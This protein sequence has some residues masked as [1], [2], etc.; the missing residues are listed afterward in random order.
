MSAPSLS[1]LLGGKRKVPVIRQSE[2]AECGL[3]C[4]A[5]IANACGHDLDLAAMRRRFG[6][7]GV[8]NTLGSLLKMADAL[9][10]LA[11]PL[12]VEL[13]YLDQLKL[14]TLLHW[15][16]SH[17]VVLIGVGR[18]GIHIHDPGCGRRFV[19]MA[20][21]DQC[22]TGVAVEFSPADG[23]E[24]VRDRRRIS[25]GRLS[26]RVQ[27]L[28]T[29]AIQVLLL[30]LLL[31]LLTLT[32][33]LAMQW[34]LDGVLTAA[35]THLLTLVGLGCLFIVGFQA[36]TQ[37]LRGVL[38]GAIG[39]SLKAQWSGNL[40][41]RLVHLPYAYFERREVGE[42]M[43]RFNS[44]QSVQQTLSVS[45]VDAVLDGLTVVLVL[46][47][48]ALYSL[49]L[50]ALV[51]LAVSL[52]GLARWLVYRLNYRLN[53]ERL[54]YEARQQTLMLEAVRA[55][56]SIKLA[57]AEGAR[58]SRV[59][60]ALTEVA[61]R[62]ARVAGLSAVMA[63]LSRLIF[64]LLRVALL[65]LGAWMIMDGRFSVGAMVAFIAFADVFAQKAAALVDHISELRLLDLHAG[66]IADIALEVPEQLSSTAPGR[67]LSERP[68][69]QVRGVSFRYRVDGPRVLEDLS[70]EIGAGEHVAI[71][72]ASGCGKTTL[73][74]LLLGLLEPES[75]CICVDGVD[76]RH[77]GIG[78]F[79]A[80]FG[81]VM[82]SDQL[83][84]GTIADNI[85]FFDPDADLDR[86]VAAA[87][88]AAIHDDIVALPMAYETPVGDLG[89]AL[90]GGQKQRV[91]LARALYRQPLI[92]L[93]DEA[94]SHLDVH[95]ERRINEQISALPIT[96]IVIAHRPQTIAAADRVLELVD[97]RLVSDAAAT[98]LGPRRGVAG[99][100]SDSLISLGA[101][102]RPGPKP[103]GSEVGHLDNLRSNP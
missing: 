5:M 76:A 91:L 74:K 37:A 39:A 98:A 15:R 8:G 97:G 103:D 81:A 38:V 102:W 54:G 61:N 60:N 99:G 16:M 6:G 77:V 96:R 84:S 58:R 7:S 63:A 73:A 90:S 40:F 85:A 45:F 72:G 44:V 49:P 55:I 4:L 28:A 100:R 46:L 79:R 11:R 10:L 101:G 20:E 53:E 68:V 87:R 41:G 94:T 65:W 93:L 31:E 71:V 70:F 34:I 64:G 36:L 67:P 66:R 51:V 25:L 12:R 92:L 22:F 23:F 86:I 26:G 33:P 48:L 69:L 95:C 52:Y 57:G 29:G 13:G 21:V 59:A 82:Q 27:G 30:A 78:R 24:P 35:D 56:L 42:I 88:S 89:A 43:S 32:L 83:M 17:F 1:S 19:P 14:P 18:K 3:A 2:Y 50:T 62:D 80:L 75:G 47:V 9:Q